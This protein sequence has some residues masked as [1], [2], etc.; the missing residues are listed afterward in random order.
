MQIHPSTSFLIAAALLLS[1]GSLAAQERISL[2]GTWDFSLESPGTSGQ[3]ARSTI[4][5]P[6]CWAVQGFEE[7]MYGNIPPEKASTGHYK[8]DFEIPV[9]WTERRIV[10]HFDGVWHAAHVVLNGHDLGTHESGYTE[11]SYDVTPLLVSGAN[12]LEVDVAQSGRY[13]RFDTYDDWSLGGIY[14]DVWLESMP[15]KRYLD[16]PSVTTSFDARYRD[17]DL[18]AKVMVIDTQPHTVAGNYPSITGGS[19]DV[20]FTLR[21]RE[22]NEVASQRQTIE[23]QCGTGRELTQSFHLRS[24]HRWN[25]EDPYLYQLTVDLYDGDRLTHSRSRRVGVRQVEIR[26]GRF[27]LNGQAIRLRGVNR[28]DEHPD[29]GRATRREHW[30]QDLQMMKDA[31]INYIRCCHYTPARG[32]VELCDSLGMYLS[33]E[34]T[35]G[36]ADN[37]LSDEAYA[38]GVFLRVYET[39][40]RDLS[41]PSILF[42]T[43]GNEDPLTPLHLAAARA[44]RGLDPTR[45]LAMPWRAETWLP[46]EFQIL[47][48]HY[49]QPDEEEALAEADSR[50]IVTTEYTHGY[51]EHGLGGLEARW[52]ALMRHPNGTG[53]AVWMWQDQ[54]IRTP[55]L[56]DRP[57]EFSED[58]YLRLDGQGWDGIVDADRRPTRDLEEVKAVYAQ[59]YPAVDKIK[60]ARRVRIPIV[61]EFDFTDLSGVRILWEQFADGQSVAGGEMRMKTRPHRTGKLRLRLVPAEGIYENHLLL[62]FLRADGSEITRRSIELETDRH[63]Q[64]E[65]LMEYFDPLALIASLR[66][67]IWHTPDRME[68]LLYAW[69]DEELHEQADFGKL[70]LEAILASEDRSTDTVEKYYTKSLYRIDGD[71]RLIYEMEYTFSPDCIHVDYTITPETG[72]EWVPVWG[73]AFRPRGLKGLRYVGL[74]PQDAWPNKR[75]APTFGLWTYPGSGVKAA[76]SVLLDLWQG[77]LRIDGM[78]YLEVD[79]ARP[80]EI[81]LLGEVVSR[82]EKGRK[83]AAPF[84]LLRTKDD[85]PFQGN[86]TITLK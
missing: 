50:P 69:S 76:R 59:V 33:N 32:F 84:P 35:T 8:R 10:L 52:K 31:N 28:H 68:S 38:G 26:D 20:V 27:L 51:S 74:G 85:S 44:V 23:E 73:L 14:R 1:G 9:D 56:P 64:P 48:P 25:A 40:V 34:V 71:N 54:G 6:G 58:P 16:L 11:F 17:A 57:S 62:T 21:D 81:L 15:A 70:T 66:P 75:S 80:D 83:A 86:I 29:V 2:N 19:Y 53:G 39:L 24:P 7:P 49:W 18:T 65:A 22:G 82:P 42:W 78:H 79:P 41:A 43:I 36:Y 72:L 3:T 47:T 60:A 12:T 61:N 45:P 37:L 55:V 63:Y 30:L 4:E 13:V 77:T 67:V 5:V 46:Q